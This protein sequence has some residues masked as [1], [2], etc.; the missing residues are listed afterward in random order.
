MRQ[1]VLVAPKSIV[2]NEIE[3]PKAENLQ[4]HEVLINVKR[5]GICGSEI[6]SYHGLHPATVYPVVQGHEF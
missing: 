2:F 6:H 5:I 4:A 1:A 3:Q